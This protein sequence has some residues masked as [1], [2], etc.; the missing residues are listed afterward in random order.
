MTNCIIY[1]NRKGTIAENLT[2]IS[3]VSWSCAPELVSGQGN[4][5]SDP[6]FRATNLQDYAILSGSPG[7]NAGTNQSWITES[8]LDLAGRTRIITRIV[9]MGAYE[10]QG[11]A[12]SLFLIR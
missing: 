4:K 3:G 6:L 10:Y 8:S 1:F 5:T 9:D 12:G 7:V 11:V 2:S